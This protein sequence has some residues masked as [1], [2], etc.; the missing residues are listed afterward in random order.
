MA[1]YNIHAGHNTIV[2]GANGKFNEVTEDRKVKDTVI[3]KLQSL[4]YTVYDCTDD[5]GKTQNENLKNIVSKCNDHTV[6]LDVSIHFNASDGQG[7]G[8]EVLQYSDKTQAIAQNICN[9]IA[10]LGFKNRGVKERKDL[11]VLKHTKAP[12]ILIECCFCDSAIDAGLYNCETMASAIVKGLTGVDVNENKIKIAYAGHV[13][14]IGW[15]TPVIDGETCGSVGKAK[16]LEAIQV[17]TRHSNLD[18]FAKAHIANVGWKDYGKINNNTVIG[19][20]GQSKALECLC[21]NCTNAN[22]V[23]RVHQANIGWSSWT[24]ADGISTLGSVGQSLQL[25]AIEIKVL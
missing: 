10:Q 23:Y 7:H 24:K 8:V 12:A 19:T 13:Q 3:S 2:P 20:V 22:I 6:D 5:S 1:I 15:T 17:D 11:Y 16:R 4:G 18:M 14:D 9:A 25:E 21:L